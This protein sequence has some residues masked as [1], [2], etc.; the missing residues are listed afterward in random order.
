MVMM[1]AV[2]VLTIVCKPS[3]PSEANHRT[4]AEGLLDSLLDNRNFPQLLAT[5]DSLERLQAVSEVAADYYRGL[6]YSYQGQLR[7]AEDCWMEVVTR[8]RHSDADLNY[9]YE[10]ASSLAGL[11]AN[12]HNYEGALRVA[13]PAVKLMEEQNNGMNIIHATL[14]EA[15]GRCQMNLERTNEADENFGLAYKMYLETVSTNDD[16]ESLRHAIVFAYNTTLSY[17]HSNR[18]EEAQLWTCRAD[19]LVMMYEQRPDANAGFS[20]RVRASLMLQHAVA[21]EGEG[22]TSEAAAYYRDYMQTPYG[23][24]VDGGVD[25]T[26]YLMLAQR[27]AE[28]VKNYEPLD[29]I[30]SEW[31]MEYSLDNIRGFLFPKYRANLRAGRR[32]SAQAVAVRTFELL[33]SAIVEAKIGEAAEFAII[34]ETQQKEM[35]IALQQAE[36]SRQR[37]IGTIAASLFLTAFFLFYILYRR[38]AQRRLAA[39]HQRLQDTFDELQTAYDQLRETTEAKEMM[40]SELRVARDIQLSM[41]PSVFPDREG[42]DL[43][44]SM[45]AAKHV[46][47]DLYDYVLIGHQ[48][49]FCVG[50]VAG[51]GVPAS[52]VMAQTTRLFRSLA[53]QEY[54][55]AQ[56]AQR[57]NS[58]MT[59]HS[60]TLDMFVTMFIGL[61]D[62]TTGRL[63]FCN[64]GHNP[65]VLG[66]GGEGGEFLKMESNAPVGL[67][68]ELEYV[69]E[70]I[71]SIKGRPLFIYSDGLTEAEN[72]SL[73]QF[74]EQRLIETLQHT[75]CKSARQ[76]I[77]HLTEEVARYRNGAEPND[78]VTMM[79]LILE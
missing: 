28:A 66:D 36:L 72:S 20:N 78:D 38:R 21:L 33:D 62:L 5:A 63:Q 77:E 7:K 34:Y 35:E 60:S 45:V 55:P 9:Y 43:Y 23:Q 16:A 49:Y 4:S 74:G 41:V 79:C 26:S 48:L 52:L 30:L 47:G 2:I 3:L 37:L 53:T 19:S 57:I 58:E 51:K 46:G 11:M 76:V 32:D 50:D 75:R 64:A 15:I 29:S 71:T 25:A 54:Q 10:T 22:Q 39:S 42:L 17:L 67:W 70:E 59:S 1:M 68:K 14:H 69:G 24:S 6:A 27:F 31:G 73:Q 12:E 8:Q 61:L 13:V 56:I 44:A 18:Y 65:P 40:E